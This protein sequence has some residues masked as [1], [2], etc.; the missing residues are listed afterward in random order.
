[1]MAR[2]LYRGIQNKNMPNL[3]S[4]AITDV[5]NAHCGYCSFYEGIADTRRRTMNLEECRK[6]IRAAQELGVSII[7]FV[8]GEPLIRCTR[9]VGVCGGE[10]RP[11]SRR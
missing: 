6:V 2:T 9:T 3:M 5:C 1:M 4:F 11:R 7:N 8:G 10:E